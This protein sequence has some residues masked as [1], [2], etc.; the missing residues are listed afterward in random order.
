MKKTGDVGF[1]RSLCFLHRTAV[2]ELWADNLLDSMDSAAMAIA[3][4]EDGPSRTSRL[5]RIMA[6]IADL[7][8]AMARGCGGLRSGP[9]HNPAFAPAL[10]LVEAGELVEGLEGLVR[11]REGWVGEPRLLVRA[12]RHYE[13]AVQALVRQTVLSARDQVARYE[14]SFSF[15]IDSSVN[16]NINITTEQVHVDLDRGVEP[17]EVGVRVVARCPARLDLTGGWTDTP[18]ICYEMG[19]KVVDLA[20]QVDGKKPIGCVAIR[21]E[22]EGVRVVLAHGDTLEVRCL[23]DMA[24]HTNPG[25]PGALVKC[26][27]IAA[28]LVHL[29]LPDK[30]FQER[31]A[32]ICGGG[33]R[34]EL[35]SDLPQ[36]SGLGTSSI[37][38]GAVLAAL[39]TTLGAAY[40]RLELVHAVLVVEQLLTTGGGW[41][42]QVEI[43]K[44][45]YL[46]LNTLK[47]GWASS[48]NHPR[49]FSS[50]SQSQ[51]RDGAASGN[52][53]VQSSSSSSSS[54]SS[55][56]LHD[57]DD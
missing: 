30:K 15:C 48:R 46:C 45:G 52:I 33:L 57:H 37:L 11:A 9:A 25:A 53:L 24:D 38:A 36:G 28:G 49:H 16:E 14:P 51:G 3:M 1:F 27:L 18:P 12:A 20:I 8:G 4:Q 43:D 55:L 54:T 31:L 26:C 6:A 19:G 22:K 50:G 29:D 42:D 35:W 23:A 21:E 2:Q 44:H 10:A 17:V 47:G 56:C 5:A 13:G 41:Q 40:N 34:I 32:R 7:L 39:W